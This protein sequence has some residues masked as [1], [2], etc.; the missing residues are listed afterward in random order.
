M[1]SF[2]QIPP[3]L[4][5]HGQTPRRWFALPK[6]ILRG[7]TAACRING[8]FF[9]FGF[10]F[11]LLNLQCVA[12]SRCAKLCCLRFWL[13]CRI[14]VHALAALR[15]TLLYSLLACLPNFYARLSRFAQ[16]ALYFF[17]FNYFCCGYAYK[18]GCKRRN[19]NCDVVRLPVHL[20]FF[21][22]VA[23]CFT[24]AFAAVNGI[25]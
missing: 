11:A 12:L 16:K 20:P 13:A 8:G 19:V 10:K 25:V 17:V 14:I 3:I 1:H 6:S 5:T 9:I 22:F 18:H 2:K 23:F 4:N 15:K 21:G 7:F 24:L